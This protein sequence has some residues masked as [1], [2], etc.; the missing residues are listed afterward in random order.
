M[1]N[2]N[3]S[4]SP[5]GEGHNQ[6]GD[7]WSDGT[8][9]EL[10]GVSPPSTPETGVKTGETATAS[11]S[12][13]E[14]PIW[15]AAVASA[16]G[17][18]GR[19]GKPDEPPLYSPETHQQVRAEW[20]LGLKSVAQIAKEYGVPRTT[21]YHWARE[22]NW[23]PRGDVQ[24]HIRDQIDSEVIRQTAQELRDRARSEDD[25]EAARLAEQLAELGL[26]TDEA[27]PEGDQ[28][29]REYALA[30]T[31]V[32]RK[33]AQQAQ[34]ASDIGDELLAMF[35]VSAKRLREHF[36]RTPG[37]KREGTLARMDMI[38]KTAGQ[39]ATLVRA[40]QIA[41]KM[42]REALSIERAQRPG[43]PGDD[44]PAGGDPPQPASYEEVL[45]E[46]QRRGQMQ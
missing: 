3:G 27:T 12:S 38:A 43:Q 31:E 30:V 42:Q 36:D 46:A 45:L 20:E 11:H 24:A 39:F 33:H 32:L 13:S 25:P 5:G 1:Q 2:R 15:K 40:L 9:D 22:E 14:A 17:G 4:D 41:H 8:T 6:S 19:F 29:V 10:N 34:D 16:R 21:I 37:T 23:K 44:A 18:R 7:S 28:V 26:D 35:K